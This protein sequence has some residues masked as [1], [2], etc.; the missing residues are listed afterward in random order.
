[1]GKS[2]FE[3]MYPAAAA[4]GGLLLFFMKNKLYGYRHYA[5]FATRGLIYMAFP[6]WCGYYIDR[7]LDL[8]GVGNYKLALDYIRANTDKLEPTPNKK[9]S[10]ADMLVPWRPGLLY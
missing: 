2:P 7:F 1:M 9:Y 10:D 4:M 8:Q 6:F 3:T 5:G